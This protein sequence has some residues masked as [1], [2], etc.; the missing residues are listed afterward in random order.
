VCY[1]L[2]MAVIEIQ[3]LRLAE[4]AAP[5]EFVEADRRVQVEFAYMQPGLLRRTTARGE[6][7]RDWLVVSVWANSEAADA[8]SAAAHG[9]GAVQTLR[10][11]VDSAVVVTRRY[12]T[13]E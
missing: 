6:S 12:E 7:G 1:Q 8:A 2:R 3:T 9:D 13:L 11:L 4:S 5:A 10:G